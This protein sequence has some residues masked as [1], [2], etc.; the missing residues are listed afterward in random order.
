[1]EIYLNNIQFNVRFFRDHHTV[2]V[3]IGEIYPEIDV[4]VL[5]EVEVFSLQ[6]PGE[7]VMTETKPPQPEPCVM[8]ASLELRYVVMTQIEKSHVLEKPN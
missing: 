8:P 4:I 2:K 3:I 7:V 6:R 5:D 1:M